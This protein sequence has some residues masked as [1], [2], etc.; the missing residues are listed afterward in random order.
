MEDRSSIVVLP[1]KSGSRVVLTKLAAA[2]MANGRDHLLRALIRRVQ[3]LN[4]PSAE[5]T[6]T[7]GVRVKL[8]WQAA[9]PADVVPSKDVE[10]ALVQ[11]KTEAL[12]SGRDVTVNVVGYELLVEWSPGADECHSANQTI[13]IPVFWNAE[14]FE[15]HAEAAF[16][17]RIRWL[18]T[19]LMLARFGLDGYRESR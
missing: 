1:N 6:C 15:R 14:L 10:H 9:V 5:F 16:R 18:M 3:D 17:T 11:A 13:A 8:G 12:A 7:I 2:V 19:E 4:L